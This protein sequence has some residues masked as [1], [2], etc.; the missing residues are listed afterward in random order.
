MREFEGCGIIGSK[1]ARRLA[2][3]KGAYCVS[4][5]VMGLI[6]WQLAGEPAMSKPAYPKGTV[7]K[8]PYGKMPDGTAVD[9]YVLKNGNGMTAKIITFGGII[10]ELHVPD[11][12]GKFEDVVLGC[13]TL[14]DYVAGHPYFGCITGRVANRVAKGKFTLDG[15]D[16]KLFVN[17]GPN[18][19]HGGKKGFDKVVWKAEEDPAPDGASVKLTYA[20]PD[21][22]EGYPGTLHVTVRYTLMNDNALKIDYFAKT[23]KPTPVNLTN[24][25]Y[26]NL[27]GPKSHSILD[28]EMMIAADKY[29]PVDDT[30]IPTGE[31][32]PVKGTPLDFTKPTPIGARINQLKGDPV[33]YDHN[34]VLNG[35]VPNVRVREPKSGRVMEMVTTEPG[36]Q[37]YTGNFLDGKQK[38]KGG[39]M[40]Q[41]HNALCLEAQHFPD[42]VNQPKFPS[43]ILQPAKEYMQRTI[44]KFTVE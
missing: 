14:E 2:M 38:G 29:T 44:Y 9:Q 31:L 35:T 11:K 34:F 36:V 30:L 23:D 21:G 12:S 41:K 7:Q 6:A 39:V 32:A 16:Y 18:A 28:H 4:V 3:R 1:T 24:H 37:F 17:N 5:A 10:T 22:E 19:L 8:M 27:A 25:T 40:Y 33:G 13:D 26:F 43:I 15:K 42:S 20:S